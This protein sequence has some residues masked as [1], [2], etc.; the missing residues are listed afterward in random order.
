[1]ELK[2]QG[3]IAG[4]YEYGKDLRDLHEGNV[5]LSRRMVLIREFCTKFRTR[6]HGDRAA[7]CFVSKTTL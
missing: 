3:R 7:T 2:K 6:H 1:M 4:W 5:R